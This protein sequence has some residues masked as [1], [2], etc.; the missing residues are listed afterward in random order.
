[1]LTPISHI[2]AE[3]VSLR[4]RVRWRVV[5]WSKDVEWTTCGIYRTERDAESVR[6]ALTD[7]ECGTQI[8]RMYGLK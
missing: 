8:S 2:S 3:Q 1:M 4:D 5:R 7:Q 6:N